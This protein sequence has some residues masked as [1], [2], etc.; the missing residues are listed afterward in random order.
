GG[1]GTAA[2]VAVCIFDRRDGGL[3]RALAAADVEVEVWG[4]GTGTAQADPARDPSAVGGDDAAEVVLGAG[5]D[6][7]V[8]VHPGVGPRCDPQPDAPGRQLGD[9]EGAGVGFGLEAAPEGEFLVPDLEAGG[10]RPAL[11]V[12]D[13]AAQGAGAVALFLDAEQQAGCI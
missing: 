13:A 5:D 2:V 1:D 10:Q 6:H 8:E 3:V 12:D 11:A 9:A 7:R 4:R